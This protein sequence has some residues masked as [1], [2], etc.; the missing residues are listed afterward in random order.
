MDPDTSLVVGMALV[1]LSIPAIM[2]ALS[3]RRAPRAAA[4]TL[5]IAGGLVVYAVNAKPGGYRLQDVPDVLYSVIGDML[6]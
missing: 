2:S 4:V 5:V 3:D 6:D 1:A